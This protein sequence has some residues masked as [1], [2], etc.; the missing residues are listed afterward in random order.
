[1]VLTDFSNLSKFFRKIKIFIE[2]F[3]KKKFDMDTLI[4]T[5]EFAGDAMANK[6][7]FYSKVML[8]LVLI[9]TMNLSTSDANILDI[10]TGLKTQICLMTSMTS[11]L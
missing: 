10:M 11:K 2:F 6:I 4:L 5:A 9:P 7:F 8:I 3:E 1:M